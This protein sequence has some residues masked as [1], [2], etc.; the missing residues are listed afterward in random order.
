MKNSDNH[1]P[2][3][4]LSDLFLSMDDP[5]IQKTLTFALEKATSFNKKYKGKLNELVESLQLL[6]ALKEFEDIVSTAIKPQDYAELL[7][8]TDSVSHEK[9]AFLQKIKS[10]TNE[11]FSELIFF[12]IELGKL[13]NF[14]KFLNDKKLSEYRHYFEKL[15]NQKKF[16]LS[17]K[18]EKIIEKKDLSG[19]QAFARLFEL[20]LSRQKFKINIDGEEK[21]LTQSE[22]LNL[23]NTES[24]QDIRK[25]AAK[26]FT[27]TLKQDA[28]VLTFVTNTLAEDKKNEDKLRGFEFPEDSRHLANETDSKAVEV[29][30][31]VVEDY[32]HLTEDYYKFKKEVL[33]LQQMYDYD[34]YAPI[35]DSQGTY[36]FQEAKEI[37][38]D[39]FGEINNDF[40]K[41]A[42]D[43]FDK[44]W[45]DAKV[46][47]GKRSGAY[48]A[49]I[50]PDI[51]P[52]V[53]MNYSGSSNDVKTLAHEL[54]HAL[55]F[56]LARKQSILNYNVPLTL[57][58]TASIF[59]EMLVFSKL[60]SST[61]DE[62]ILLGLY[63]KK[64]EEIFASVQRQI[65][66]F[67][68]EQDLHAKYRES[69][70]LS[71]EQINKLWRNRQ[72][73]MFGDSIILT[74]EYD[75]WW[76]HI[77]HFINTPFYVY[78]YAFGEL[79]GFGLYKNMQ[80]DP[81]RFSK[82]YLEFL[83]SGG[84]KSPQELADIFGINLSDE[85]FWID[86][87]NVIKDYIDKAKNIYH[88]K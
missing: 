50:A 26:I 82:K 76:M 55:H 22:I 21:S 37:V 30:C 46:L 62:R 57:A 24:R 1:V 31:K 47:H 69:G 16:H 6:N 86:G 48:C 70:E 20:Q 29:M 45:I 53:F 59:A 71:M 15:S 72:Q 74:E 75:N 14:D 28:G 66:M 39:A 19:R 58:E 83:E 63:M 79:L 88:G 17:E 13:E 5:E 25:K 61:D 27:D 12:E 78:A 49:P 9:G 3:W 44:N 4:N 80:N 64:I 33:G 40:A 84:K 38:I 43:F 23:L 18:E 81:V 54:G 2:S 67:R 35:D 10:E 77:P 73:Q 41:I 87:M 36:T 42:Q 68:F 52:Y 51:H 56:D 11:I 85:Q 8:S 65:S 32:Y 34:R 7:H 60:A